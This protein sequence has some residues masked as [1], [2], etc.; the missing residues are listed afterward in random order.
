VLG[1]P[2][3]V[4]PHV[5]RFGFS[6]VFAVGVVVVMVFGINP[7]TVLT[8]QVAEPLP[9]TPLTAL[10]DLETGEATPE[11]LVDAVSRETNGFWERG[12]RSAAAYYPPV[13]L[14]MVA[15][16]QDLG[17]GLAGSGIGTF[18]C[19]ENSTIYVDMSAYADLVAA[20]P[21]QGHQ[22]ESYL[23][24]LAYGH[25]VQ[26]AQDLF[27]DV[28][29]PGLS[30]AARTELE[31]RMSAQAA[32]YNGAST[33]WAGL[34]MLLDDPA[35]ARAIAAGLAGAGD[36]TRVPSR[37]AVVLPHELTP[38]DAGFTKQWFDAGY[39]IPAIGTCRLEK[40][41]TPG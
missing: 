24:G 19:P 5:R 41:G 40:I 12:F 28:R 26:N 33:K 1:I 23:I 20:F 14:S 15:S 32:C 8:G 38:A 17:C 30:S 9:Y 21:E 18:Y 29:A 11:D 36:V 35:T 31:Q 16:S 13:A 6:G 39:A 4:M 22:A 3:N 7:I 27:D 25:H 2:D 34:E 10:A 37:T